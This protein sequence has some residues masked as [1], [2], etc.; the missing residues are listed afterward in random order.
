MRRAK[1]HPLTSEKILAAAN[2]SAAELR[3]LVSNYYQSQ[4]MRKRMDM[5][6]RHLGDRQPLEISTFAA[7]AFADIESQIAKAFDKLLTTRVAQW[8]KAQRGIGPIIAAGLLAHIDITKAPTVGHIWRFAGL[9]PTLKW[10][11]GQKRPFNAELKQICWHAGQ[12]FLKQSN[13]PDCY[14]GRLYRERKKIE[15]ARNEAGGN[16]ER[17]KSFVVSAGAT[18]AVND[19]LADGKLPDFNIDARARRYAVKIFLS[20]LHAVMFWDH[21]RKAPPK[22][23]VI[24]HLGHVHELKIPRLDLFPGLEDAYYGAVHSES[25][26]V[27][28]RA[29]LSKSADARERAEQEDSTAPFERAVAHES[30]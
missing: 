27:R 7:E 2:L 8:I 12:C 21:Y 22:P 1:H 14:Y 3:L 25:T 24:E 9:D 17:A 5:Q 20:H 19:K 18:K 26:V 13:D 4:Q 23:F 6:L 29:A 16:I 30:N 28:E 11:K 15:I 10:A